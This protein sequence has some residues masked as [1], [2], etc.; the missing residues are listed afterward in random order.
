MA[1]SNL[2]LPPNFGG[3]GFTDGALPNASDY[4]NAFPYLADPLPG[5]PSN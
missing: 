3:L 4:G 1:L 2:P 5:S